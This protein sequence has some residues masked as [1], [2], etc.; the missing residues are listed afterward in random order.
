MTLEGSS[1]P[2]YSDVNRDVA[3]NE[4]A[5]APRGIRSGHE[6]DGTRPEPIGLPHLKKFDVPTLVLHGED[7]LRS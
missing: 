1:Q 2:H 6:P 5:Q 3:A 4:A 7:D